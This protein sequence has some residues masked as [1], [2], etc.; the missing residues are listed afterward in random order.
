MKDDYEDPNN[1]RQVVVRRPELV[2]AAD[3]CVDSHAR[4]AYAADD[5]VPTEGG[6]AGAAQFAGYP[7]GEP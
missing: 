3:A 4:C 5:G 7:D 6:A 2:S 1:P